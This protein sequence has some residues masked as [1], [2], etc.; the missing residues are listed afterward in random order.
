MFPQPYVGWFTIV[1]Q[2]PEESDSSGLSGYP[3]LSDIHRD[4]QI[5]INKKKS[6]LKVVRMSPN[7][8]FLSSCLKMCY[9]DITSSEDV[10]RTKTM[11]ELCYEASEL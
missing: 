11:L 4:T 8:E 1:T 10:I 5:H 6:F 7:P 2:T 9:Y 3:D